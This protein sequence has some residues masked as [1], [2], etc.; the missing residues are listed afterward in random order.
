M[1]NFKNM[2]HS[3]GSGEHQHHRQRQENNDINDDQLN[4]SII[5]ALKSVFEFIKHSS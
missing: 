3:K 2:R 5:I 1:D 4:V